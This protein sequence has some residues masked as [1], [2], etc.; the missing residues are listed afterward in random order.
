MQSKRRGTK[1]LIAG[2]CW[3]MLVAVAAYAQDGYD[4]GWRT[5][6]GG[7]GTAS[8][9][10]YALSGTPGQTDAGTVTGGGYTLEGGFWHRGASL[11][12]ARV[13]LPLILR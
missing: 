9:G 5:V 10:E 6:D 12:A 4:L 8:G 11:G 2:A 13:Y 1:T 3:L 7:G